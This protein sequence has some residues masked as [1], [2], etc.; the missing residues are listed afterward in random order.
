MAA[1]EEKKNVLRLHV[2]DSQMKWVCEHACCNQ[3]IG[4]QRASSYSSSVEQES[5]KNLNTIEEF[6]YFQGVIII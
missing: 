6:I 5:P 1:A 4:L 3:V 2:D